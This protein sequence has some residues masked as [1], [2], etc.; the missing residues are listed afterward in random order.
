MNIT[1]SYEEILL[2]HQ[3]C[4]KTAWHASRVARRKLVLDRLAGISHR[5]APSTIQ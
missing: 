5:Q 3:L 4:T 2:A 1:S